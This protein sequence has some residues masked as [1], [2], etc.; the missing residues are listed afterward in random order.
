MELTVDQALQQG[1]AA[2]KEGKLQDAERL[3]RAILQA[4]PK[5]PDA[6]HNLG[7]LAVAVGKPLEAIPLFKLALETSP[8]T[9]K[10]WRSCVEA[11]IA[12]GHDESLTLATA[13]TQQFPDIASA[14]V[15]LGVALGNS[16][17]FHGSSHALD[18]ASKLS[19]DHAEVHYNLGVALAKAGKFKP[20]MESYQRALVLEP[21]HAASGY[22]L[23]NILY[24]LGKS[25]EAEIAFKQIILKQPLNVSARC[26]LSALLT[27]IGKPD[28]AVGFLSGAIKV[29]QTHAKSHSNLGDALKELGRV[30]QAEASY[31]E[32]VF[33]AP[34]NFE[35]HSNLLMLMSSMLCNTV[36]YDE[37][38]AG[39]ARAVNTA[40]TSHFDTWSHSRDKESLRIGFVSGDLRSHPVGYFIE[41]LLAQLKSSS[42]ELFAYP[43]VDTEDE[44]TE[45]LRAC[46][47]EWSPLVGLNDL[48]AA[49]KIHGDGIHVLIDLSGHTAKNR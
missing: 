15:C 4:Q 29:D 27:E 41:G 28:E 30:E 44:A 11:L 8:Q 17:D 46:F 39:F 14:W 18:R 32:A 35:L 43:T 38:A 45:R 22:N 42:M 3:Y 12:S 25:E 19:P 7:V 34:K 6:N 10:F 21:S 13:F 24:R 1:V 33:M 2:Q 5:H 40:V 37:S 36:R 49:Q 16:G 26:N 9:E 20:A 31:R 23:S 47:H 48:D